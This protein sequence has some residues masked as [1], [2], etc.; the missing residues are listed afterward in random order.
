ME[1][2]QGLPRRTRYLLDV[3]ESTL[4]IDEGAFL[5]APTRGWQDQARVGSGF[6]SGKHVLD[7]KKFE[8]VD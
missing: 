6:R 8:F 1:I 5:F 2:G 4:R 3:A 7:Y